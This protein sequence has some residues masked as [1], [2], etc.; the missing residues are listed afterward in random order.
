ME[1]N[2]KILKFANDRQQIRF[3][4]VPVH[5]SEKLSNYDFKQVEYKEHNQPEF[6]EKET[7]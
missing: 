5:I 1:Y 7:E 2:V 6:E 4:S 3:Y